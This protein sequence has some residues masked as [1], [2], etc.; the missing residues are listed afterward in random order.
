MNWINVNKKKP[1]KDQKV[2]VIHQMDE[3][4]LIM[5]YVTADVFY[6]ESHGFHAICLYWMPLPDKPE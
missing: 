1:E 5:T 6:H 2:L 4:I 3:Q